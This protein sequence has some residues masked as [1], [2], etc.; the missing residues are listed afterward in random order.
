MPPT[1]LLFDCRQ[2]A[3]AVTAAG[4]T[5]PDSLS[6]LLSAH[7]LLTAPRAAEAPDTAILTAVLD[8]SLTAEKLEKLL[9]AAATAAMVNGYRAELASRSERVLV[10]QWHRALRDGAADEIILSLRPVFDRHAEGIAKARSLF[11]AESTAEHVIASGNSELVEVWN[12]LHEHIRVVGKITSVASQFGCRPAATFP[13][14]R[15]YTAGE[16]FKLDDRALMATSGGLVADSALFNMPDQGHRSSP[17][18]RCGGLQLHTIAEA[19]ARHD[20][21]AAREHDRI[22]SGDPGGWI[23]ESG[24]HHTHPRPKNPFREEMSV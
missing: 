23:D 1:S 7:D 21:W 17:F 22:H 3:T 4:G 5:V 9:P 19:Q 24:Q 20:Q 11:N 10:G 8:G 12:A 18:F 13:Q 6:H 16:T 14:V 2:F 15:E